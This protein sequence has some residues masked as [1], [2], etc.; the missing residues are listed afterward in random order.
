MGLTGITD[1]A[2]EGRRWQLTDFVFN[3]RFIH[4]TILV[5]WNSKCMFWYF[6]LTIIFV[7][8]ILLNKV[9]LTMLFLFS[10]TIFF[11]H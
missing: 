8:I 11:E 2:D 1:G 10:F 3:N 6:C 9:L 4:F 5:I 7:T